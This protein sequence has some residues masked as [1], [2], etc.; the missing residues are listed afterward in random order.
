LLAL[1]AVAAAGYFLRRRP[2]APVLV[3]NRR[4]RD[5]GDL[6]AAGM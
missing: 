3:A 5:V 2:P 1:A 4:Y 6:Y